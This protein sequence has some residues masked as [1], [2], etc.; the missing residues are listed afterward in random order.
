MYEFSRAIY[1]EL[2][3]H[4]IGSPAQQDAGRK[5]LL[6]V[7]QRAIEQLALFSDFGA[8]PA[9]RVFRELRSLFSASDQLRVRLV[10]QHHLDAALAARSAE[11]WS[12][13]VAAHRRCRA[14]TSRGKACQR[15]ALF[16]RQY[17]PSH[18]HLGGHQIATA[19]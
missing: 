13:T 1:L 12:G 5:R 2:R 6:Q 18:R 14:A 16:G 9:E 15:E 10:M 3:V 4:V 7:T 17:C 19:A 11:G 8:H